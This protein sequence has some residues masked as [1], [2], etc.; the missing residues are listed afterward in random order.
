MI[1]DYSKVDRIIVAKCSSIR[2][3]NNNYLSLGDFLSLR[4]F[5]WRKICQE[6]QRNHV[7]IQDVLS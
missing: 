1:N 5:L 7:H 2:V 3:E 4:L 6:N